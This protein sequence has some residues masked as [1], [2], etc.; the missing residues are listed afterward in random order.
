MHYL[1]SRHMKHLAAP[2]GAALTV[3]LLLNLGDLLSVV[4]LM[5]PFGASC[6]IVFALPD[7]PLAKT[8][9]IIGGHLISAVIG[10]LMFHL[11]GSSTWAIAL[12][13][14]LSILVMQLTGTMHPPAGANPVVIILGG[15]S[16]SF[17]I[18]PVMAGAVLIALMAYGYR[19][20]N[21]AAAAS[22]EQRRQDEA[23]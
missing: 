15:A 8:R 2:I 14:G 6:V 21:R 10:L 7:S 12:S 16:W 11:V 4:M 20:M 19:A 9:N 5:A 22:M 18:T 13:V 1:K 17:L 23:G 3:A